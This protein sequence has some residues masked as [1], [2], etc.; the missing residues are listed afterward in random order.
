MWLFLALVGLLVAGAP[1]PLGSPPRTLAL[2]F[3][4]A[5]YA[6]WRSEGLPGAGRASCSVLFVLA[7]ALQGPFGRLL[8]SLACG[9]GLTLRSL[10]GHPQAHLRGLEAAVDALPVAASL[11]CL[12]GLGERPWW[13]QAT[14]A[15]LIYLVGLAEF[16]GLLASE[17][18]PPLRKRYQRVHLLLFP[19]R[20]ACCGAAL[21]LASQPPAPLTLGLL[22]PAL[23]LIQGSLEQ[24]VRREEREQKRDALV[25]LERSQS[26]LQEASR[27]GDE[28]R[29][30]LTRQENENRVLEAASQA[31]LKVRDCQQ[32]VAEIGSLCQKLTSFDS[33]VIFLSR[34]QGLQAVY[35][36]SPHRE[37]LDSAS[38]TGLTEPVVDYAWKTQVAQ[39]RSLEDDPRRVF[40]GEQEVAVFPLG[41]A[42]VLYLGRNQE[43]FSE[44]EVSH[45]A[46]AARQGS[47]ALQIAVHFEALSLALQHEASLKGELHQWASTL[48]RL[49][50]ESLRFL[51]RVEAADFG[52]RVCEAAQALFPDLTAEVHLAPPSEELFAQVVREKVPILLDPVARSRFSDLSNRYASLLCLPIVQP[53]SNR[54]GLILLGSS[55]TG[56]LNRWHQDTLSVLATLAAVAWR[57]LDLYQETL[58]AQGHLLQSSK[59]AAVGQLAAGVAHE[60]NTPLGSVFLNLDSALRI[61]DSNPDQARARLQKGRAMLERTQSIIK[62]LLYY[63]RQSDKGRRHTEVPVLIQDTLQLIGHALSQHQV[64][65]VYQ[66]QPV[67]PIEVNQNELQQV[68]F[69]L[70]LNAR[71][72]ILSG[73]SQSNQ[74]VVKAFDQDQQVFIEVHDQGPGLE[75]SIRSRVFE[76]FFSTKPVGKG[77]GL[78]LSV[79]QQIVAN[80]GGVLEV[81]S[82]PG[83]GCIFR[84]RLSALPV[85][86]I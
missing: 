82:T 74:V 56:V 44:M 24:R 81:E 57:N 59:M 71:D 42:G 52:R 22:L 34:P 1:F 62:N 73:P 28:L 5:L 29:Q 72:A 45:L 17:L 70:V 67:S 55:Q 30:S 43:A 9:L 50:R 40:R 77:T 85:A 10:Q 64:E 66:P 35:C 63:S 33:L 83:Q 21:A 61:L 39:I 11:L 14:A 13:L 86:P 12:R 32:T 41:E 68:L 65:L 60:L 27:M 58:V 78:G 26:R 31:L 46:Q 47:L 80:H 6:E 16:Q 7:L 79:S 54:V 36:H 48:D 18:P 38:L 15:C 20:L 2:L 75:E 19:E 25:Q 53:D 3:L 76:P 4:A 8:A 69:N 51:E 49:L 23:F 84:I 37:R